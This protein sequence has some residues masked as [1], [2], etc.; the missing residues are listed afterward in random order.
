MSSKRLADAVRRALEEAPVSLREIAQE[1]DLPPSTVTRLKDGIYQIHERH[2][3]AI[4][5]ALETLHDRYQ[6]VTKDLD[7]SAKR[8]RRA[9]R[10]RRP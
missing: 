6:K 4:L 5:G 9:Q 10:G 3:K 2:A 1:A 8:I 7:V